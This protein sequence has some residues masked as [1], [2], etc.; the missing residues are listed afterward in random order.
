MEARQEGIQLGQ[1]L[2]Q[3]KQLTNLVQDVRAEQTAT[4]KERELDR[5]RLAV[6]E[7]DVADMRAQRKAGRMA[8]ETAWTPIATIFGAI[9]GVL[10]GHYWLH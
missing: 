2:E 1:I 4:R 10:A 8:W 3:L 9:A 6:V 5:G 7:R